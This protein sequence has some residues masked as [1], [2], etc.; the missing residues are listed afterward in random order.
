MASGL[1]AGRSSSTW[2][3]ATWKATTTTTAVA[4]RSATRNATRV[5]FSPSIRPSFTLHSARF[6]KRELRS[7]IVPLHCAIASACLVS[8]LPAEATSASPDALGRFANYLS[9]I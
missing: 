8:K 9:P 2:M 3:R 5:S 4:R 7:S 6:L 1:I